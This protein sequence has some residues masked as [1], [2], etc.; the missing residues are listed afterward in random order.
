MAQTRR[1]ETPAAVRTVDAQQVAAVRARLPSDDELLALADVLALLGDPTRL[2]LVVAL[3]AAGEMCVRDLA[4]AA[5]QS[6]SAVSHALRLL[7]AHGVVAVRRVAR[8]AYYRLADDHV[9]QLVDV[10]LAHAG[11]DVAV[12][13]VR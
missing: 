4:A 3:L 2:R 5:G 9:R 13:A 11:H 7:R 6:E 12:G 1:V 8:L 10:G